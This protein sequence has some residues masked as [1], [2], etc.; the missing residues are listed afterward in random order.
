MNLLLVKSP[1]C[2]VS[3][4]PCLSQRRHNS[5]TEDTCDCPMKQGSTSG[6]THYPI[7][8]NCLRQTKTSNDSV[9]RRNRRF[10][11][12]HL[13]FMDHLFQFFLHPSSL[14]PRRK[15]SSTFSGQQTEYLHKRSARLWTLP[16]PTT[17]V[18]AL[19]KCGT[20]TNQKRRI[21]LTRSRS[22]EARHE[23]ARRAR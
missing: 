15:L 9:V 12:R 2:S 7:L 14:S 18:D 4:S 20:S 11:N 5:R 13:Q 17:E 6:Y 19:W 16:Q 10:Q 22:L 21:M 23:Q 8:S 3:C 1:L